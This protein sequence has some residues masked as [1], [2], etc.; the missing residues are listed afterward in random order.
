VFAFFAAIFVLAFTFD[1]SM[2]R[3]RNRVSV[4]FIQSVR[5]DMPIQVINVDRV[6]GLSTADFD[7]V[8]ASG[9]IYDYEMKRDV[10]IFMEQPDSVMSF[11][12]GMAGVYV[13]STAG[14][15]GENEPFILLFDEDWV[16]QCIANDQVV[17]EEMGVHITAPGYELD[18]SNSQPV[19]RCSD[20]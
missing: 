12:P 9:E 16:Q 18:A 10:H 14:P 4:P 17:V 5:S 3:L 13:V 6:V 19:Y 11:H 20:V 7:S 15:Q 1:C 8:L 2:E